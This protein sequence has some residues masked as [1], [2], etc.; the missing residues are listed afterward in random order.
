[1]MATDAAKSLKAVM[2]EYS[3]ELKRTTGK[4]CSFAYCGGGWYALHL[5]GKAD[6]VGSR[7]QRKKIERALDILRAR[8]D[9]EG[10][11]ITPHLESD[12]Q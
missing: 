1:M 7:W 6:P 4:G 8:P 10:E 2:A 11:A 3:Q 9:F 5:E 12:E